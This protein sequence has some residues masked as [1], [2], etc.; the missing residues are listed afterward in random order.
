MSFNTKTAEP[1]ALWQD[2]FAGYDPFGI[3][4][5]QYGKANEMAGL[6]DAEHRFKNSV[7]IIGGLAGGATMVP[8]VI[9]GAIGLG[10]SGGKD[11]S[12]FTAPFKQLGKLHG[13]RAAAGRLNTGRDSAL[14]ASLNDEIRAAYEEAMRTRSA[15][16]PATALDLA[17]HEQAYRNAYS[18]AMASHRGRVARG[19]GADRLEDYLALER[20]IGE[21]PLKSLTGERGGATS[22]YAERLLQEQH[23][24]RFLQRHGNTLFRPETTPQNRDRVEALIKSLEEDLKNDIVAGGDDIERFLAFE[25]S[26]ATGSARG[27][28]A[29]QELLNRLHTEMTAGRKDAATN[30]LMGGAFGAAGAG[31]QYNVG[32][33]Q[34]DEWNSSFHLPKLFKFSQHR[35]MNKTAQQGRTN[36]VQDFAAGFDPFG[37]W[38]NQYGRRNEAAGATQGQHNISR[39]AGVAGGIVGSGLAVPSVISGGIGLIKSRGKDWSGFA[40]PFKR[41]GQV[42]RGSRSAKALSQMESINLKNKAVRDHFSNVATGIGHAPISAAKGGGG[43]GQQ[44]IRYLESVAEDFARTQGRAPT[45]REIATLTFGKDTTK[46]QLLRSFASETGDKGQ[47]Y[48]RQRLSSNDAGAQA[49]RRELLGDAAEEMAGGV[50]SG[51]GTL[52]AGGAF[53]GIG[54][55][56]QY[57]KGVGQGREDASQWSI[58]NPFAETTLEG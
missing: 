45:A 25:R 33:R 37:I 19:E 54:A 31:V 5:Q 52:A 40:S 38:T 51:Y 3:W 28:R 2:F 1:S 35:P 46:Q 15:A 10:K 23:N 18:Q 42:A 21:S 16:V 36:V 8:A 26:Q 48:L 13:A 44:H 24:D 49:L 58:T 53:G 29:N 14:G 34:G 30:L 27:R 11:W 9:S 50:R 47:Q 32:R 41:I 6:S 56:A 22:D 17:E 57:N 43:L 12:G 7:G 20:G 4:T 55:L 39:A